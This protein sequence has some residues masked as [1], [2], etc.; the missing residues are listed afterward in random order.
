[1]R[2]SGPGNARD[3]STAADGPDRGVERTWTTQRAD[4]L[5]CEGIVAAGGA[6]QAGA[7]TRR[8]IGWVE[9]AR[10]ACGTRRLTRFLV[11]RSGAAAR[12]SAAVSRSCVRVE[13]ARDARRTRALT[14]TRVI[15]TWAAACAVSL[16]GASVGPGAAS[17]L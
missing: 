9:S 1:M 17:C 7:D 16:A 6:W 14:V 15:E 3:A 4:S 10:D 11:E 2:I 13:G 8:S 5:G 12:A